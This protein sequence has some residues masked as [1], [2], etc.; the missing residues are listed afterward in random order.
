MG[1]YK[2]FRCSQGVVKRRPGG[3]SLGRIRGV[4]GAFFGRHLGRH[5]G[6]YEKFSGRHLGRL[7]RLYEDLGRHLGCLWASFSRGIS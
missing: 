1:L 7:G 6:L 2:I 4:L 5:G 3:A